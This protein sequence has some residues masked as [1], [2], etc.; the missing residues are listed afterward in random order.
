MQR[1]WMNLYTW[2]VIAIGILFVVWGI[3]T[4]IQTYASQGGYFQRTFFLIAIC[5][6]C[7][8]LPIYMGK[9]KTLD[10]SVISILMAF[11][12]MGTAQAVAVY[13]LS[14]IITFE[15]SGDPANRRFSSIY[16]NAPVKSLF[17]IGSVVIA[18]VLPGLVCQWIGWG[19]GDFTF[20]MIL[21]A[22][23]TFALLTFLVNTLIMM[24]L[25]SML[26]GLN[27]YEVIHMLIGL[28]PN[29]LPAMPLGYVMAVFLRQDNGTLLVIIM[30]SPLLLARHAWKLYIE[31]LKQQQK[32][33]DALNVA[34]EAR[35]D[36]TSGHAKR[37]SEFAALIAR[38][39]GVNVRDIYILQRGAMLHDI[40]KVGVSDT[41]LLKPGK[42]TPE[43]RK[44]I[45]THPS[46]GAGITEHVKFD[47]EITDMVRHH[48]EHYDG[49]GYP[50][51]LKGEEI[52]FNARILAVADTLD[53]MLSD[54]PYRKGME[55][56][57]ALKLIEEGAGT[58]FDPKI[59]K[60][61]LRAM[62]REKK[63]S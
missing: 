1:K 21:Y 57:R 14:S 41:V 24:G 35:D 15:Y 19:P 26:D 46:T 28:I 34:M 12:T 5:A 11:L 56:E 63:A 30:M 9:D 49:T 48:H 58:Q 62:E 51:G 37:V 23:V 33:V 44:H 13:S 6:A 38:E 4:A 59:V 2:G 45:E 61:L 55:E 32:L 54:R 10:L 60:A 42:L 39:L 52:S 20:P 8:S 17:N 18:I 3:A 50:D 53:A 43:E 31:S 16:N 25:F 27:R 47:P 40:G 7:R 29:V 22:T 36:Y